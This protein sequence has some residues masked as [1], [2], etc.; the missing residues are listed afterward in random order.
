M[1]ESLRLRR[2]GGHAAA[3][4]FAL[5]GIL[6]LG[7]CQNSLMAEH[8]R[9]TPLYQTDNLGTADALGYLVFVVEPE[10][11]EQRRRSR[12]LATTDEPLGTPTG[13]SEAPLARSE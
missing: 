5:A 2:A 4:A 6:T 1:R 3:A 7:G 13:L 11:A 8:E 10:R 9:E 12:L